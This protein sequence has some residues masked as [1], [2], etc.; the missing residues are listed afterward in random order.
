VAAGVPALTVSAGAMSR[1]PL[2]RIGFVPVGE[3]DVLRL[4]PAG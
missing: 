3:Y 1:P 4:L 2:E